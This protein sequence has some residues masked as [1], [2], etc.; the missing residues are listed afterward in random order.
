MVKRKI[1]LTYRGRSYPTPF[2]ARFHMM[3]V[4]EQHG[5]KVELT[6]IVAEEIGVE[7]WIAWALVDRKQL[8]DEMRLAE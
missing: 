1:K 2:H 3:V 4:A 5:I 6:D 7:S 8:P